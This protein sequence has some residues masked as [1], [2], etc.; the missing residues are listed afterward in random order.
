MVQMAN[1]IVMTNAWEIARNGQGKFGGKVKEYFSIALKMAWAI[2]KKEENQVKVSEWTTAN[3][4]KVYMETEHVT[5][6][7]R[8]TDWGHEIKRDANMIMINEFTVNGKRLQQPNYV[9]RNIVNGMTVMDMG[10]ITVNGKRTRGIVELP[11]TIEKEVYGEFDRIEKEKKEN[12]AKYYEQRAAQLKKD[13]ENGYCT[14]CG[15]Y[16]YGDCKAN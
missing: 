11:E 6:T 13:I 12:V 8:T 16:C 2:F 9:K 14:D 10:E 15:S 5:E 3:G 7:T 4:A 1:A